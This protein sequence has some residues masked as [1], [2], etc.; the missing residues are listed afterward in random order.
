M[1]G[2]RSRSV[3]GGAVLGTVTDRSLR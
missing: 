3:S 2:E 1:V